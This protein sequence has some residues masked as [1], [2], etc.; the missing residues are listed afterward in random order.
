MRLLNVNMCPS[1]K[2]VLGYTKHYIIYSKR[3]KTSPERNSS[4]SKIVPNLFSQSL[5]AISVVLVCFLSS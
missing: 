4:I 1:M 2:K 5:V 3:N